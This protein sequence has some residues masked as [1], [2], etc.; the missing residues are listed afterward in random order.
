MAYTPELVDELN[1]LIHY[2][3]ATTLQG[4]KVH[5]TAEPAVIAAT[6]RLHE[7]GLLTLEDGGY[8]TNLGREVAEHAQATLTILTSVK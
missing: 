7:K 1:T 2:D 3:L 6:K 5:K 8:L 4:V